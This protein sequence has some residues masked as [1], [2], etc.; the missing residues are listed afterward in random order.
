[1]NT[2]IATDHYHSN[3]LCN[4]LTNYNLI[5]KHNAISTIFIMY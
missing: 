4:S 3:P 1:M 2:I 5:N